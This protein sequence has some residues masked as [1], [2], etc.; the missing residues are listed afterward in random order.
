MSERDFG[1][2]LSHRIGRRGF[3]NSAALAT[4]ALSVNAVRSAANTPVRAERRAR[5]GDSRPNILV[6]TTDQQWAGAMSCTGNPYLNTP[7]M[8]SL[9]CNG[10]TFEVAYTPNPICV[11]ART[12]Y[13]TGTSSHENGVITNVRENQVD[14]SVPC[15]AKVFQDNDYDTGYVGKW[16]IPRSIEDKEWSG[17]DYLA[18]VRNNRVDSDIP[19]AC[20]EFV[21]RD[22]ENPFFLIASFV[23]PHDICEWARRHSGI[24]QELPNGEIGEPPP[25][26]QCPPLRA[27]HAIP[28][29]EPSTVRQHQADENMRH[30]YPTR[31]R[32]YED[33]RWRQYLW[34]YY[35]MVELVDA[36]IGRVLDMLRTSGQGENTVI[37]FTSDHGDGIGSHRWNQKTVFYDEVSRIPFI[38]SWKGHTKP[39]GRDRRHLVNLG[40]DLFPT[41]FDFAGI[42]KPDNLRGLSVAPFALGQND[43]TAHEYIV[44]ENNHHSGSGNPTDVHGRML[45]SSRYKYIRYNQGKPA[46][47]LFDLELDPGELR[48]L[49]LA[50]TTQD[51][52]D[53]HRRMLDEYLVTTR[54]DFP[55]FTI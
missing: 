26:D 8:D 37:V 41:L 20:A 5:D 4:A 51:V 11:P 42:G 35:R 18:A 17:F 55:R 38:V 15:L 45:R 21:L 10:V 16:H 12:S 46:E 32:E 48:D 7:A 40:T 53:E 39:C 33:D 23:N 3:L 34:G 1:N 31:H 50:N 43:A 24:E 2:L 30:A 28:D 54:D 13:M 52:L 9:A 6:I 44:S 49:T 29:G 14:L 47:Q 27:N 22:R 25:P 19:E 36:Y